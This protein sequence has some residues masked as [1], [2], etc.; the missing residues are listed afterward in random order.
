MAQQRTVTPGYAV[1]FPNREKAASKLMKAVVALILLVSVGLLLIVT[2]GGW[3]QL[4][5]M[6][7]INFIWSIAYVVVAFY[8]FVR[9]AR[10]MLPIAAG[11]AILLLMVA[12]VAGLGLSGTSWF[13][14]SH[15]GFAHAKSL[16]G[17]QGLSA[18]TLGTVTLLLVPVQILLI[19]FALQAFAQGWNVEQEV[20]IDEARK[21]GYKPPEHRSGEPA[22]A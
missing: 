8:I 6:K 17:G 18:D 19:I 13:D 15:A 20:P 3:S 14:R 5:G 10:G 9:W 22:T 11:L 21:R 2:I 16:L 12:L 1:V 4:E 7:P